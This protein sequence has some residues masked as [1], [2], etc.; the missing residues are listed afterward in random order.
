MDHRNDPELLE[1]NLWQ[2]TLVR[3]SRSRT[4][5]VHVSPDA[6]ALRGDSPED[7]AA[8]VAQ[9]HLDEHDSPDQVSLS[10]GWDFEQKTNGSRN[11]FHA[12]PGVRMPWLEV[13]RRLNLPHSLQPRL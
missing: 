10:L 3:G 2:F 13:P 6:A 12:G 5:R 9:K 8:E 4:I 11:E 1:Q 7:L